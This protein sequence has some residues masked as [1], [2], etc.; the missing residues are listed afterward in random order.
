MTKSWEEL[1]ADLHD[2]YEDTRQ[3]KVHSSAH[4]E[5]ELDLEQILHRIC[6]DIYQRKYAPD[7]AK[8][9][10]CED[11][12]KRE[13]FCSSFSH[14]VVCR[15]LYNYLSP[16]LEPGF[17]YDSYSCQKGKGTQLGRKRFAHHIRSCS[18]NYHYRTYVL[19]G[20][21]SGY[22]MSIDR[23]ILLNI[24]MDRIGRRLKRTGV[25]IDLDLVEYLTTLIIRRDPLKNCITIGPESDFDGIPPQKLM[26]NAPPGV[27][28]AIGDITSQLF[29]NVY[30]DELDRYVKRVL[31]CKHYGR[32]VDDFYVVSRN[33]EYLLTVKKQIDTFLRQ[34]LH[35]ALHPLKTRV[36][37]VH[38]GVLFLGALVLPHR[39]YVR[40][41]TLKRFHAALYKL[42]QQCI[43][44][45]N[46]SEEELEHMRSVLNSYLGHLRHFKA[47]REV[48]KALAH[49]PVMK[50]FEFSGD[51]AFL[52]KPPV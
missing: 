52:L 50:Y 10:L 20:D 3:T 49:S 35:L 40:T 42:E 12:V 16:L 7:A 15:L 45:S 27:G 26:K 38:M 19:K 31:K 24:V 21:L 33:R 51:Q 47:Y 17:I 13:V 25:E 30:L 1:Y 18:G 44:S 28:L 8:R 2:A 9:F 41:R 32:Y 6:S 43:R 46:P 11:P 14:R 39:V 48:M 36:I 23:E 34:R 29:S 22:F 5:F 37:P 4:I